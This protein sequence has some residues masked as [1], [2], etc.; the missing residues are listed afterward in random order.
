MDSRTFPTSPTAGMSSSFFRTP[1]L[2]PLS[3]TV[4][5]AVTST[6]N[7]FK[8]E[9]RQE[10]PVPPPNTTIFFIGSPQMKDPD[11]MNLK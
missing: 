10:M 7:S 11:L 6:G 8:P 1:V 9:R 2:L 5:T 3:L 4:M